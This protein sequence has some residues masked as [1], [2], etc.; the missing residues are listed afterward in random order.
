VP[1]KG[2]PNT[3]CALERAGVGDGA[4]LSLLLELRHARLEMAERVDLA[5]AQRQHGAVHRR[6]AHPF[7]LV[8]RH[9][10]AGQ[11]QAREH[12]AHRPR[13]RHADAPPAQ[14]ARAAIRGQQ[15]HRH[16]ERDLRHAPLQHDG[17]H[18]LAAQLPLQHAE[19]RP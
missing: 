3:C 6:E 18:G 16:P 13:C 11:P 1:G 7:D 12:V 5:R 8:G 10:L 4:Q 15:P 17:L 2:P 9:R 14:V 19:V